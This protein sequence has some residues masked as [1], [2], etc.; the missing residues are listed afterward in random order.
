MMTAYMEITTIHFETN[1]ETQF[2]GVFIR[3]SQPE[4]VSAKSYVLVRCPVNV[5]DFA[6]T[7]GQCVQITGDFVIVD[8]LRGHYQLKRFD[9]INPKRVKLVLPSASN[10][11]VN[12][13]SKERD[14]VGIGISKAKELWRT[15]GSKIFDILE[16][17]QL[18]PLLSILTEKS[19]VA[20]IAGFEKYQTLKYTEWFCSHGIP[21][22]I[23]QKLFKYH[24]D[25]VVEELKDNPYLLVTFG[26]N[27]KDADEIARS[28]FHI[29]R[30]A[31]IRFIAAIEQTIRNHTRSGHT[32][33]TKGELRSKLFDIMRNYDVV[34]RAMQ[35][36]GHKLSFRIDPDTQHYHPVGMYVT[37]A[38]IAKR[39]VKLV[40]SETKWN[41]AAETAMHQAINEL[42][43]TLA[44][45]QQL[46][47]KE[48]LS[49]HVSIITG[50]AGTGKTTI[51][52]TVL[53]AYSALKYNIYP[54]ALS[55]RAAMRLH[56]SIGLPTSTIAKFLREPPIGAG[57]NLIV[58]DEASMLDLH[59]MYKIVTH[60]D[61]SVRFLLV[62]DRDQ[63]P[64][65]GS[66]LVL[67]DMIDSGLISVVKLDIVQR[68]SESSG[69]PEYS[70][71]V[72]D[73]IVPPELSTG[74]IH[75][76]PVHDEDIVETCTR[77]YSEA[78]SD[79]QVVSS[80]IKITSEINESCQKVVNPDGVA[81]YVHMYSNEKLETDF[82]INDPVIFTINDYQ[83]GVQNGTLGVLESIE[84][85]GNHLGR[86]RTDDGKEV[87]LTRALFDSLKRA[88]SIT[89]HKAQGS[90]F[91][92]TIV[93]LDGA[94]M[95]DRA[96]LYTAITRTEDELHI[97]GSEANFKKAVTSLSARYKRRTWLDK[98]IHEEYLYATNQKE[99]AI[100]TL[101]NQW[102]RA[103]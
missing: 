77:L 20:L 57:K 31:D 9:F 32:Y 10:E 59:T 45:K 96:W 52:K 69:I 26:M 16:K 90:Q 42:P 19:A 103:S 58:I 99:R 39:L 15:Y 18:N 30:H 62:G 98:L 102:Q 85:K 81:M 97:V 91:K 89:L 95:V 7:E 28:Y 84:A 74:C 67:S 71:S 25:T 2:T 87:N 61:P 60:S 24:K 75:F 11:F 29:E 23:Q 82:R 46:A 27:F 47:V 78:P 21:P 100:V 49:H 72:N 55:G 51:L 63:L 48:A 40:T 35:V 94:P 44:D 17:Q 88:Y 43:F 6:P 36:A 37:E 73:G 33:M 4:M 101:R 3:K 56:E 50:G 34:D 5:M 79:S 1:K 76:H 86:V 68:Q 66:G 12:F 92:R 14:F 70:K 8:D 22:A 93:A 13:I 53:K 41:Y 64:S 83:A 65:I 54:M 80:S 38:V